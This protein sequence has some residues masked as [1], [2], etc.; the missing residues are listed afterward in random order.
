MVTR[1]EARDGSMAAQVADGPEQAAAAASKIDRLRH[2]SSDTNSSCN[3]PKKDKLSIKK[4]PMPRIGI[5]PE[6]VFT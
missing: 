4:G 6:R 3:H 2:T 1:W 5:D